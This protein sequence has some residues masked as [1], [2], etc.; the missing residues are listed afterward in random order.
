M[1]Y[2]PW[3]HKESDTNEHACNILQLLFLEKVSF[4]FLLKAVSEPQ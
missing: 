4:I 1:G 2:S 3:G